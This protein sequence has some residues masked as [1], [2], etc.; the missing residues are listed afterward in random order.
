MAHR[1]KFGGDYSYHLNELF[2]LVEIKP[3]NTAEK[4][5]RNKGPDTIQRLK[6]NEQELIAS[7]EESATELAKINMSRIV[8]VSG[9]IE[10]K[11]F[12]HKASAAKGKANVFAEEKNHTKSIIY[13]IKSAIEMLLA[14]FSITH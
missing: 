8:R 1:R 6:D 11:A 14:Y 4:D 13:K 12:S 9:S 3:D 7:K 10:D 5:S 2:L